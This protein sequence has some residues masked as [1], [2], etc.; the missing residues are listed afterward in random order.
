MRICHELDHIYLTCTT[1]LVYVSVLYIYI[2][3]YI[4]THTH[5]L[6]ATCLHV[7]RASCLCESSS[8]FSLFV[9][10][11]QAYWLWFSKHIIIWMEEPNRTLANWLQP[12]SQILSIIEI[13]NTK[14]SNTTKNDTP[15]L[16]YELKIVSHLG[17]VCFHPLMQHCA[18]YGFFLC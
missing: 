9:C 14:R 1:K 11:V 4:Y 16:T 10:L 12:R 8:L 17:Y 5:T 18:S 2:Y 13:S 6:D 7:L 15:L 3:I